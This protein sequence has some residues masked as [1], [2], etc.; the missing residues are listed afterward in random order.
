MNFQSDEYLVRETYLFYFFLKRTVDLYL[1][2]HRPPAYDHALF[3]SPNE[4]EADVFGNAVV[5][6]RSFPDVIVDANLK[7]DPIDSGCLFQR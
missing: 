7:R 3:R 1:G 4:S 5:D 2:L 6:P